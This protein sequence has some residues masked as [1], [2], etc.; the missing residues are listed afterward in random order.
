MTN[1]IAMHLSALAAA[2][3]LAVL[4]LAEG[5]YPVF[6]HGRSRRAH[7]VRNVVLGLING[8]SRAL[9]FPA[10]LVMVAT[11]TM[12]FD[13][14]LLRMVSLP[15]WVE[16]ALGIVLLDLAG[17][18]WHVASHQ[19]PL[20]WRFHAVHHHDDAV[21]S[22]TAFRFHFGDVIIG[23]FVTLMVVGVLGLRVE[24]VL[25]YELL[26]MPLSIFHHG[27]VR[28]PGRVDRVLR[29]LIV[30]PEMHWV[31]HSQWVAE[32]D[33]N[34]SPLFSFWDRAF[35]T[36][37]VRG[38]PE[39]IR[40]GLVGYADADSATLLGCLMT[41]LGPIK[42]QPGRDTRPGMDDT[43][44][45][46]PPAERRPKSPGERPRTDSM[47]LPAVVDR[48]FRPSVVRGTPSALR[49][50]CALHPVQRTRT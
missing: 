41:P 38:D 10:A 40:F 48:D 4:W 17:Y 25:L 11:T 32:T 22:T 39:E 20:L 3:A 2:A 42:S 28:L 19:W 16:G 50:R 27:N 15:T 37:R 33:S 30:T 49:R 23:S 8:G 34:Y 35:G 47:R 44:P 18:A 21:D 31:H 9:F 7:G 45:R 12:R 26:L 43:A 36:L 13:A 5:L 24:H 1:W 46:A 6:A 14:G 29:W